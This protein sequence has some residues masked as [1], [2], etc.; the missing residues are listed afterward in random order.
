[1][2][3]IS[4]P[5]ISNNANEDYAEEDPFLTPPDSVDTNLDGRVDLRLTEE[6]ISRYRTYKFQGYQIYQVKDPSVGV[7]ELDQVDKARL[8]YQCDLKDGVGQ[9]VNFVFDPDLN[10][11]V[12]TEM[13]NG[14]DEGIRH[15]FRVL[16]DQ[17]AEG[18]KRL[19]NHKSYYF[20]AISYASNFF[21]DD[22]GSLQYIEEEYDPND[23]AKL[24]GQ[25]TPYLGSRKAAIGA[26]R[27]YSGIPHRTEVE[28]GGL[29]L[30]AAYGDGVEITRV[31]GRG[32][33][34]N[35][36]QLKTESVDAI[37]QGAPWKVETP[38]Y[39]KGQGPVEVK[40]IDPL[41]VKGGDYTLAFKEDDANGGLQNGYWQL[42]G[43]GLANPV[44]SDQ[45][46]AI[47][48]EQLIPQLGISITVGNVEGTGMRADY[49]VPEQNGLLAAT[50]EFEDPNRAWLSGVQDEEGINFQNW[51][52]SGVSQPED[53]PETPID[54]TTFADIFLTDNQVDYFFDP[55]GNFEELIDG[56]WAPARMATFFAHGPIGNEIMYGGN[57]LKYL[58]S[59][60]IVLTDDRSKWTR[61]QVLEMAEEPAR[62]EDSIEKGFM[63]TVRSVDQDG[64]AG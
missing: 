44:E 45:T 42:T 47:E 53:N 49:S 58:Q 52:R 60:D 38:T 17:F 26:I 8:I 20:M 1:M 16:E 50:I 19:V 14:A 36:L 3:Y 4:N 54:E 18:D 31:E 22:F 30:N 10:G 15:S 35:F 24:F 59:V 48:N 56:T 33:G 7:S 27:V 32:N 43:D 64:V 40:V 61:C 25:R 12:P 55:E 46:I 23:P 9:L 28:S 39:Q 41:N 37:M 51:I 2:L 5:A 13:V 29:T 21:G 63:R 57:E 62:S 34:G 11:N 6:E